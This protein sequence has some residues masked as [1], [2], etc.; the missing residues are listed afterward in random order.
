MICREIFCM[1]EK[2]LYVR[3]SVF[4]YAKT[5]ICNNNFAPPPSPRARQ[6]FYLGKK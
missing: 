4:K 1:S 6:Q 3:K 2:I 5:T